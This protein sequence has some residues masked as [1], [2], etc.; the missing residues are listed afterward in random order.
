M[1]NKAVATITVTGNKT[2]IVKKNSSM[3]F[4]NESPLSEPVFYSVLHLTITTL[5]AAPTKSH[6]RMNIIILGDI[7]A[8]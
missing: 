5:P 8:C 1:I 4:I 6:L 2:T 3:K 7:F